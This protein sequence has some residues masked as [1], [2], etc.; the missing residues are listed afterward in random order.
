MTFFVKKGRLFGDNIPILGKWRTIYSLNN[1][2]FSNLK[3]LFPL[4]FSL[5][6]FMLLFPTSQNGLLAQQETEDSVSTR[7]MR[8][9]VLPIL[10][11]TPETRLAFGA[12]VINTFRFPKEPLDSRPSQIQLGG[13]YTLNKQILL[14]LPFRLYW[15]RENWLAYGEL[16][17]YK[18]NYNYFGIGNYAEPATAEVYDVTFPRIRA[19]LMRY[20]G[21]GSYLGL[22]Y[23]MDNWDIT[24]RDPNGLLA[25]GDITG[26]TGGLVSGIGPVMNFDSRDN[27]F[28]PSHGA[29]VEALAYFNYPFMGSA[30]SYSRFSV[31][32]SYFRM[33]PW[34]E[35]VLA[36]NLYTDIGIGDPPFNELAFLGGP[37]RMRGYYFGQFR[38]RSL[39]LLQGEYR[40]RI[41]KRFSGVGFLSYGWVGHSPGDFAF[42]NAKV[43]G[44]AGLRYML[45][46]AERINFRLDYGYGRN[47]GGLYFTVG[48]AF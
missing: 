46:K 28:W 2:K 12:A 11:Y 33:L 4:L 31:D 22:R 37:K 29:F 43:A 45:D 18:Y 9:I 35:H 42:Q 39:L 15:N 23:V 44:G 8:W 40:A 34:A 10:Y 24:G 41:W 32:A 21:S 47:G 38:D 5:L 19:S 36:L 6:A 7:R 14:Y 1:P 20:V 16:G 13:A 17:Y 27:I 25:R 26:S 30:F 3:A 48:E